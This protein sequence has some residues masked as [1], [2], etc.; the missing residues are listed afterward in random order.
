MTVAAIPRW[1]PNPAWF[2]YPAALWGLL[3]EHRHLLTYE[4]C[5]AIVEADDPA[6]ALALAILAANPEQSDVD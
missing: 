5:C 3:V 4:N 1:K 2:I 6:E